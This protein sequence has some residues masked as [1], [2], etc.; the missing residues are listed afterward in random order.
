MLKQRISTFLCL[1]HNN[2][3]VSRH[4]YFIEIL[5][6]T[7]LIIIII[8]NYRYSA[9][10]FR[11]KQKSAYSLT[12]WHANDESHWYIWEY[13]WMKLVAHA[14]NRVFKQ[15]REWLI[16]RSV[17][18]VTDHRLHISNQGLNNWNNVAWNIEQNL[19]F[20]S[21]FLITKIPFHQFT[22]LSPFRN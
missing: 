8:N 7:T 3:R 1:S 2:V 22:V 17:S 18:A 5:A 9:I 14:I 19:T 15:N 13:F 16:L 11:I 12:T 20:G 21:A 10:Y 4:I 6:W